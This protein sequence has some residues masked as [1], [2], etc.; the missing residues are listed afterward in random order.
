MIFD[1][2][3]GGFENMTTNLHGLSSTP[4]FGADSG[5]DDDDKDK[6]WL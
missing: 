4:Y 6:C 1:S 2:R 3:R 5:V